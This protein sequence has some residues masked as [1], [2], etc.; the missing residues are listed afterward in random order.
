[1]KILKEMFRP[2]K[3]SRLV[4]KIMNDIPGKVGLK[5]SKHSP[6]I[7]TGVGIAGMVGGTV[8]ACVGTRKFIEAS[9]D[10]EARK[11]LVHY[12]LDENECD[13]EERPELYSEIK[14]LDK[15]VIKEAVKAY[16]PTVILEGV[17][18]ASILW[19]S[20]IS[21]KRLVTMTGIATSTAAQFAEYRARVKAMD[22]E[23]KDQLYLKGEVEKEV[24]ETKITKSGKE[25]TVKKKV[26]IPNPDGHS[27]YAV[28]FKPGDAG[29]SYNPEYNLYFI[30][31]VE[32]NL[33]R[34]FKMQGY[35]FLNQ[36]YDELGIRDT[37]G[38][39]LWTQEGQVVGWFDDGT[40]DKHIS[41]GIDYTYPAM[42]YADY[43][44]IDPNV[45]GVIIDKI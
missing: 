19:G 2:F 11:A 44:W 21:H 20:H 33:D 31:N 37:D 26:K 22:G 17:S 10:I 18:V 7:F 43:V 25:R 38:K 4:G 6:M 41:F 5:L 3:G 13:E 39:W 35:L 24:E 34:T 16:A 45:D 8:L 42:G 36:V 1:M 32:K 14:D 15:M 27:Q 12:M 40:E 9:D 23:N 29:W 28:Q 30:Q